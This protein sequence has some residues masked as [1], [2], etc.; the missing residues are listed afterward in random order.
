VSSVVV[1]SGSLGSN[2]AMWDAQVSALSRRFR[3]ARVEHPGHGAAPLADVADV[4]DLARLV[5]DQVEAERF[6]F[7]GLS[8]GGAIGMRIALDA[9][10][11]LD[12][13]VLAATAA[14]FD[15]ATYRARAAT[16]R[17]DGLRDVVDGVMERWFT[18]AF[19]DV[20][21]YREMFLATDPEGYA[22]CSEA[23]AAWNVRGE[24]GAVRAP[25]LCIAGADDPVTP[26]DALRSLADEIPAARLAVLPEARHLANVERAHEFNALLL[27]HLA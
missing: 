16:V 4:S 11:R 24:L 13:L 9:P 6:S 2:A 27:E 3:V 22:R 17:V 7:V 21:R 10:E 14:Q 25:T 18:P 23:V 19:P 26:P 1:L 15:A 5:L 12:L 8:L 20:R